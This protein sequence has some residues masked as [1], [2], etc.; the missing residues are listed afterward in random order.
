[1]AILA[2]LDWLKCQAIEVL[3]PSLCLG[4]GREGSFFCSS[5]RRKLPYLRGP[6]CRSCGRPVANTATCAECY[7]SPPEVDS[8]RAPFIFDGI[9]RSAVHQFKYRDV[10]ALAKPL[11][12]FL[13]NYIKENGI[14]TDVL[15]PVP[16]HKNRLKERG[17]NQAELL[18][19][20]LGKLTR[21]P[22]EKGALVRLR[23]APPQASTATAKERRRN[24]EGAFS[25]QNS[26]LKG[27]AVLLI[28]D[29]CTTGA[30]I[31]GCAAVLKK[32][33]V[34]SVC[35]LTVAREL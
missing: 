30:T 7:K 6:V 23:D 21:W 20:Q 31:N 3:F 16:L 1:M 18:A 15:V 11:A 19:Q 5:C 24:V 4:C 17:Y 35:A 22:V 13:F 25:C 28:D 14:R 34:A 2:S 29:V 32:L 33:P 8:M 9:I 10:R 26:L 27:K 12:D